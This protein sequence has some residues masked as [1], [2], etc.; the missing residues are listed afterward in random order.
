MTSPCAARRSSIPF[1]TLLKL[2]LLAASAL[3]VGRASR[4]FAT[5]YSVDRT[6]DDASA[7]A[8]ACTGAANDCSLRGAIIASNA[9]TGQPNVINL[10]G[11]QYTL[12]I[13][14]ANEDLAATGDLD[15]TH[16]LTINGV[17]AAT[18]IIDGAQLDRVFQTGP[19]GQ[20]ITVTIQ[21]VTIQNGKSDNAGFVGGGGIRNGATSPSGTAG[22]TLHLVDVVVTNN[23]TTSGAHGGGIAND[24]VMTIADSVISGNTAGG[25]GG[26]IVQFDEGSL[27]IT[28]TTISGNHSG[29]GGLGGGLFMGFFSVTAPPVITIDG[30]AISGNTAGTGGGICRNRGTITVT[31]STISGNTSQSSGG[32]G[33]YDA[34]GYP[35]QGP[36]LLVNCTIT[37]NMAPL[38]SGGGLFNNGPLGGGNF[39]TEL[40]NTI[41]A[42]NQASADADVSGDVNSQGYNLFGDVTGLMIDGASNPTGD[43]MGVANPHLDPNLLNNGGASTQT[44]ALLAGSPAIDAGNPAASDG[45]GVHCRA[46]DQIGTVRPKNGGSGIARC[47]IGAFEVAVPFTT[48]TPTSTPVLTPTGTRTVTPTVTATASA[49]HT[50]TPSPTVTGTPHPEICDNCFDDDNNTLVDRQDPMC[51]APANGAFAGLGDASAA[52]GVL[53][54]QK[55][56]EKVGAAFLAKKLGRLDKCVDL[57][58]ACVQLKNGDST[59]I[60]KA[61]SKCGEKLLVGIAA[62]EAK[63]TSAIEKACDDSSGK[64]VSIADARALTGLGFS[65]EEVPCGAGTFTSF[66]DIAAC[67]AAR[68]ECGAERVLV[69]AA[70]RAG[71]ML[72]ALGFDLVSTFPCVAAAD[73]GI[74]AAGVG[75]SDTVKQK[76]IL[77][78]QATIKKAGVKLAKSLKTGQKCADAAAVCIQKED[79]AA[80]DACQLKAAP[81]CQA[82]LTKFQGTLTKLV[83]GA[84]KKCETTDIG[85]TELNDPAGLGFVATAGRCAQFSSL[86]PGDAAT[87]ALECVVARHLCEG[88]QILERETPRIREFADFLNVVLPET[89]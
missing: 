57:A 3:T 31:N 7:A 10:Q 56:I 30:S 83:A 2:T 89:F 28:N 22:G 49:T 27:A 5:T 84:V 62:D 12:S 9:N 44:H 54:C 26:G 73:G 46:A 4:A 65:A 53:K 58:L 43:Q 23:S 18:T 37:K 85:I 39:T 16:D 47:D 48:P 13:A 50:A 24:G 80:R 67:E 88:V 8:Q 52:K 64:G 41:V 78:C 45:T 86:P 61:R 68:H 71:E 25:H 35:P 66:S 29:S 36:L 33:V 69:A 81:K 60:D 51:T 1:S 63:L 15:I 74:D 82:S 32:G 76:A 19:G 17:S 11:V 55:T 70:P 14:G 87:V 77:K 79:S 21:H 34:G 42:G 20:A 75:L 40:A 6:D 38:S 59:C 72:K